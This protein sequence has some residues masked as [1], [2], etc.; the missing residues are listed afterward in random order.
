MRKGHSPVQAG[1]SS[2]GGHVSGLRIGGGEPGG[3]EE[4][5]DA[6]GPLSW[7]SGAKEQSHPP[8]F[9]RVSLVEGYLTLRGRFRYLF[10][11]TRQDE[12]IRYIQERV[13]AYW[14]QV[15]G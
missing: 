12:A 5:T 3:A 1:D 4:I 7:S 9:L 13:D 11:P 6:S 10:E 2:C 14:Q 15:N 8:A